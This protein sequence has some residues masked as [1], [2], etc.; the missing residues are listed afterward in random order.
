MYVQVR[1]LN[2]LILKELICRVITIKK[3]ATKDYVLLL[4][5]T[6]MFGLL[7]T[8]CSVLLVERQK[9]IMN[10]KY[11]S[12]NEIVTNFTWK[13]PLLPAILSRHQLVLTWEQQTG[14][15]GCCLCALFLGRLT[16]SAILMHGVIFLPLTAPLAPADANRMRRQNARLHAAAEVAAAS[17]LERHSPG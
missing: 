15:H 5:T 4:A 13:T 17:R 8:I 10:H 7:P 16:H 1:V 12:N 9:Y 11:I 2:V 14:S 3:N 6:G